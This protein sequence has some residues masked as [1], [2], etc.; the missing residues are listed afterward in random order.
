MK[1]YRYLIVIV[2]LSVILFSE[3][4]KNKELTLETKSLILKAK[5][6]EANARMF[7]N[8]NVELIKKED[9][10]NNVV[11]TLEKTSLIHSNKYKK[12]IQQ[13]K[14]NAAKTKDLTAD[15]IKDY[16][17]DRYQ[18]GNVTIADTTGRKVITDLVY[19]DSALAQ[20]KLLVEVVS[21]KDS[22]IVVKDKIILNSGE[23]RGNLLNANSEL[24]LANDT[25][26][27]AIENQSVIIKKEKRK[28][29]FLKA[30]LVALSAAFILK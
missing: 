2:V 11:L 24:K 13:T 14:E 8:K 29:F 22:I 21:N 17:K 20:N 6:N 3:G 18:D 28:N 19:G 9:S 30:G 23:I 4:K 16:F 10:L 25:K 7:E 26:D 12:L 5:Q 1:N 27:K 15:G